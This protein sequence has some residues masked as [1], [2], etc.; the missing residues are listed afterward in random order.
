MKKKQSYS[1]YFIN[2]DE[3]ELL[4]VFKNVNRES[5]KIRFFNDF[6]PQALDNA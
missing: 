1:V 6:C 3:E 5:S 2:R 4:E